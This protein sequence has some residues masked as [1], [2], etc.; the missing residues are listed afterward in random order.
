MLR[1]SGG[2]LRGAG[3]MAPA[4]AAQGDDEHWFPS[5]QVDVCHG[6]EDYKEFFH[7]R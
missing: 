2:S 3:R 4:V 6:S 5:G 7:A 1:L